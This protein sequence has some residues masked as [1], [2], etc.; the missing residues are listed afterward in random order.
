MSAGFSS[1]LERK[2]QKRHYDR[3]DAST[4]QDFC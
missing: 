4:H 1:T 2:Q 3:R